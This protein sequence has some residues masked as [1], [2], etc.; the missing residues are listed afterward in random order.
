[1]AQTTNILAVDDE[2]KILEAVESYLKASGFTVFCASN[3]KEALQ[4]F[5]RENIALVILDLMLP[6]MS[7][8]EICRRIRACSRIPIIMLTAK[9]D[10]KSIVGGFSLGADDYIT[11]PFRLKELVARIEAILR[12]SGSDISPLTKRNSFRDGDLIVDFDKN[13]YYKK[14]VAISLTK[15]ESRLLETLVKHP[16]RVFSRGELIDAAIGADYDGFE[17]TIDSHIKNLRA[18]IE[19]DQKNPIYVVTV[20]GSGYKFSGE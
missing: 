15:N 2:P 13:S 12:R 11:K 17:R 5:N 20:H 3:G 18:K 6:D 8:E 9:V 19:D 1:M 7:G 10:E 4:I 16:G 14:G